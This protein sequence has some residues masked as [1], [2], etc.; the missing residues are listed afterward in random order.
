M[1]RKLIPLTDD[2]TNSESF[3]NFKTWE[4]NENFSAHSTKEC[5]QNTSGEKVKAMVSK[6]DRTKAKRVDDEK[7]DVFSTAK[8]GPKDLATNVIGII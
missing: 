4:K 2:I 7:L 6:W 8:K 1:P 3:V 5:E